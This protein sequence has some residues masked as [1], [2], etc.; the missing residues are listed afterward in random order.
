MISVPVED[1]KVRV[2]SIRYAVGGKRM[3]VKRIIVHEDYGDFLNDLA[4]LQL[5][6]PLEFNKFIQPIPLSDGEVPAGGDVVVSGWGRLYT[7]GPIPNRLQ[8]NTL[9]ALS[10]DECNKAIDMDESIICLAHTMDNGVCM[11][12]SGGPAVHDGKLV[13]AAGFVIDGCGSTNPDGYAKV[14]YHLDWIKNNMRTD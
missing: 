3:E 6:S 8:W 14:Y 1:I 2:G 4:L 5:E 7:T 12:D 9:T 10:V 13:G 11:G